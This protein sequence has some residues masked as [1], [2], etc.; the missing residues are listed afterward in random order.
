MNLF[1]AQKVFI[2]NSVKEKL[3][4]KGTKN[5]KRFKNVKEMYNQVYI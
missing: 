5:L 3:I 4:L 1:Q 2:F